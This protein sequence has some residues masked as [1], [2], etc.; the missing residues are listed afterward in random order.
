MITIEKLDKVCAEFR[1]KFG[2]AY[3]DEPHQCLQV[4]SA[5]W[6]KYRKVLGYYQGWEDQ[7]TIEPNLLYLGVPVVTHPWLNGAGMMKDDVNDNELLEPVVSD[8]QDPNA[9]APVIVN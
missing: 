3:V 7:K 1:D 8:G 2:T 4:S 5:A 9:T 6:D